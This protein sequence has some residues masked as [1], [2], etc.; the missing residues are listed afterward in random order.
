VKIRKVF[1]RRID[2]HDDG[3]SVAGGVNAAISANVNEPGENS[4]RVRS[5]QRIV[6][7]NGRTVVHESQNEVDEDAQ[8]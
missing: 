2:H 5:N 6:Q 1:Q 3:V 7:V 8:P 4:V